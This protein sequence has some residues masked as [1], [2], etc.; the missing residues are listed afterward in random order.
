MRKFNIKQISLYGFL[1]IV[2]AIIFSAFFIYTLLSKYEELNNRHNIY[3]EAYNSMLEY[4]YYTERL[5]TTYNLPKEKE[6]WENSKNNF[7]NSMDK[8]QTT[9]HIPE[10]IIK[11]FYLTINNESKNIL[12]KLEN[13]LFNEKS[14]MEK[15]ILRRLGEG[16]NSNE[17]SDYYLALSDLKN[18]I[19]YLKQYEGFLLEELGE[20]TAKQQN[21]LILKINE[22]KNK[23]VMILFITIIVGM[24]FIFFIQ[25]LIGKIEL[26]L[27]ET[28]NDLQDTLDE[29]NYILNTSMESIM[30]TKNGKC[31]D[32]N[33]ETLKTFG[34]DSKEELI[35]KSALN[36]I[37]PDSIELAKKRQK[38]DVVAPYEANCITKEGQIMPSLIKAYNYKNK[39]GETIRVSAIIN[40]TQVK[41]QEEL[42]FQQSKMA[43]M[44]EMLENIAHQWRQPLSI[45]STS[46][47]GIKV[48]KEYGVSSEKSE[49]EALDVITNSVQHLSD[50]IDDFRSFFKP[51]KRKERF[52]V[53]DTFDKT[54]ELMSSKLKNRNITVIKDTQDISM[55]G[56]ENELIQAFMNIINNAKD[57]LEEVKEDEKIIIFTL[58]KERNNVII[59][60]KD[61]AGGIPED[62]LPNIFKE[63]FT[64]K[65]DKE[66]TGIGLYMTKMII[67]KIK[68]T[69]RAQN[70]QY[71]YKD[72]TCKGA[73]FT[74]TIPQ[75]EDDD[76]TE[77]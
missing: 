71:R 33:T 64:T 41:E 24:V 56:Y 67:E 52:K 72:K 43:T 10:N 21:I 2:A 23:A 12:A 8:L 60:I 39:K 6:L 54:E 62:I 19:D 38:L 32:V 47:T 44:G 16:L 14:V 15:S 75:E 5:L 4:K 27:I 53:C 40:L 1:T 61:N 25:K 77:E 30:I 35:G 76:K 26:A 45:I 22:L 49:M 55:Y 31:I 17:R 42:L 63:H 9:N 3:T 57:A 46:A 59:T 29:A 65:G 34:Y 66:G 58:K 18:S 13:P 50:T 20:L 73:L 48:Q 36:F 69:I 7:K 28:K 51:N 74:I 68:G 70:E 11:E 37:A